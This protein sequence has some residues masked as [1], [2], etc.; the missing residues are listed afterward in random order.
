VTSIDGPRLLRQAFDA[1]S[2]IMQA[3]ERMAEAMARGENATT[4]DM[5]LLIA[6]VGICADDWIAKSEYPC[7]A[8]SRRRRL[9]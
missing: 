6:A 3:H 7:E 1:I 5:Q 2:E 9:N 4:Q 8:L